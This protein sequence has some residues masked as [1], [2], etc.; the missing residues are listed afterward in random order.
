[1]SECMGT[2]RLIGVQDHVAA[3]RVHLPDSKLLDLFAAFHGT[4]TEYVLGHFFDHEFEGEAKAI[5]KQVEELVLGL[6]ESEQ[7]KVLGPVLEIVARYAYWWLTVEVPPHPTVSKG[8]AEQVFR[9]AE[10]LYRGTEQL[11]FKR[12]LVRMSRNYGFQLQQVQ[13]LPVGKMRTFETQQQFFKLQHRFNDV[14]RELKQRG[15]IDADTPKAIF[16]SVFRNAGLDAKVV[17][18]GTISELSYFVKGLVQADVLRDPGQEIWRITLGCFEVQR[19][20]G[21]SLAALRR[22]LRE[23]KV[24]GAERKARLDFV[25]G[26]L[27]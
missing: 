20:N 14:E 23:A 22:S 24:P 27:G 19:A 6:N 8:I 17:W 9:C 11:D 7:S 16:R 18:T 26:C 13:V 15:L 25:I 4:C 1:M 3:I 10:Q 21:R 5:R 2:A 12:L